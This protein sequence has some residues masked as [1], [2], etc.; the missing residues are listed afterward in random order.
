MWDYQRSGQQ[1][2]VIPTPSPDSPKTDHR[3]PAKIKR[4]AERAEQKRL[5]DQIDQCN[6]LRNAETLKLEERFEEYKTDERKIVNANAWTDEGHPRDP[7]SRGVVPW[8]GE[9]VSTIASK[10]LGIEVGEVLQR[11][12]GRRII[13]VHA[14]MIPR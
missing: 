4:D 13:Y 14:S 7:D 11:K 9:R 12:R 5:N 3:S 8:P 1:T 6:R 10:L 2:I